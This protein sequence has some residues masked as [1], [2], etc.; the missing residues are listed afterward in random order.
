MIEQHIL[1][2]FKVMVVAAVGKLNLSNALYGFV[3]NFTPTPLQ[4]KILR[5]VYKPLP[6]NTLFSVE[7][8]LNG[9]IGDLITKQILNYI[10][11]YG[12]GAPGLFNLEHRDGKVITLT[13][14]QGVTEEEL[15]AMVRNLL[16]ANAPIRDAA[17][18][19]DIIKHHRIAYDLDK[20]KNNEMRIL[21]FRDGD[22][23][24]NGDDA[25]RYV[26]YVATEI[27][28]LIKST[29]VI[30]AI[31]ATKSNFASAFFRDHAKQLAAV[32]HR[33][34]NL[35]LA[36][37][38]QENRSAINQISRMAKHLHVPVH[39]PIAKRFIAI[40]HKDPDFDFSLLGKMSVRDKFK[41]LNLIAYKLRGNTTD[42]FVIRNGK[43][44]LEK[45]RKVLDSRKLLSI[46]NEVLH[47]LREDLKHLV[48][49]NI[50]LDSNV[51]YG[52]PISRKQTLG[53]LPFGTAVTPIGDTISSGVYW[54]NA[55]G[56]TDL[57]LSAI[58]ASGSRTGWGRGSGY[59][60]NNPVIFSGDLTDA[61][62][63]AMEF[64]T[65]SVRYEKPYALF[66][67]IF[68]G[69]ATATCELVVGNRTSKWID[70]PVLR[71]KI[72][73]TSKG[74]ILGFVRGGKFVV[75]NCRVNG[76]YWSEGTKE[77][78]LVQRGLADFWTV[79]S[80]LHALGIAYYAQSV[81][82]KTYDHDLTYNK[83]S[84]DKLEAL[85]LNK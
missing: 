29:K 15:G 27:P 21:L 19:R 39:E 58:D 3:T 78:A 74:T 46:S 65:S 11:V 73:L 4:L 54:E 55:W 75:Y 31:D 66:V 26:C 84:Y 1:K 79:S 60:R 24:S 16:Y 7:E 81:E 50:L 12:L 61:S 72:E 20:I 38:T 5:E 37:K 28:M 30:K 48:G 40:A 41:F 14:V 63:G 33:H 59:S 85:L 80:L 6:L 10:E 68:R 70:S 77:I 32:F 71:E 82:G 53:Q 22:V 56:A 2:L 34:K 57:D 44:H 43:V 69:D 13:Y 42:A 76:S 35:I 25:V 67:N 18:L 36:A 47:S 51:D 64:M 52:L 23:F 8:R 17:A 62:Q 49:Q 9:S 83:F 45:G